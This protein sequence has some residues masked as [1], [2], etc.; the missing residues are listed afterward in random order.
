MRPSIAATGK[1]N[2][3]RTAT[4][5]QMTADQLLG[6][7]THRIAYLRAV[8]MMAKGSSCSMERTECLWRRSMT[9][10]PQW[11]SPPSVVSISSQCTEL[12]CR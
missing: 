11:S 9:S 2:D 10:I 12:R 3:Q 4:L 5:R 6:L 8:R 7:G 1:S